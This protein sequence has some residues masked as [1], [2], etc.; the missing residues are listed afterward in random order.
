MVSHAPTPAQRKQRSR[1]GALTAHA[2]GSTNTA[3]ARAKAEE[4]LWERC[5]NVVDPERVLSEDE[6]NRRAEF[7]RL[8]YFTRLSFKASRARQAAAAARREAVKLE[9]EL[10]AAEDALG[11][12][13]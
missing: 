9:R 3:P 11:G 8:A 7:A 12:A 6:R 10:K 1:L 13:A 4:N 5:L 2:N